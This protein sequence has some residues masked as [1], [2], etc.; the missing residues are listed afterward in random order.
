MK[1]LL[2]AAAASGMALIAVQFRAPAL[3]DLQETGIAAHAFDSDN[4]VDAVLHRACANCHSNETKIP[5]FGRSGPIGW[6]IRRDVQRARE[7]VELL[8][9]RIC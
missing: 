1:K 5:W 7:P 2:L 3:P 9:A 8:R 4:N 6:V